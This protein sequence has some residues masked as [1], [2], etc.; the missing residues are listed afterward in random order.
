MRWAEH[1][2]RCLTCGAP[3]NPY[4][5]DTDEP[6]FK[7]YRRVV[8]SLARS[9]EVKRLL[10]DGAEFTATGM[11]GLTIRRPVRVTKIHHMGKEVIVD[12]TDSSE[13]VSAEQLY[14]TD[15][16]IYRDECGELA[17]LRAEIREIG[18]KVVA[19]EAGAARSRIQAFINNG[20]TPR[21]STLAR[22][23]AAVKRLRPSTRRLRPTAMTGGP[24]RVWS[25]H[26]G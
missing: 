26:R 2:W 25:R 19:R 17:E 16:V 1:D 20:V 5:A 13:E 23:D 18:V 21:A 4:L 12:P 8:A 24:S 3:I 7:T 22:I 9:I 14:A 11:R 6:I 10:A 15:P